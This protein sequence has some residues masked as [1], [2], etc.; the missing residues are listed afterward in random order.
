M[1]LILSLNL[2]QVFC[3]GPVCG[4]DFLFNFS[5]FK[6]LFLF[7]RKGQCVN[8]REYYKKLEWVLIKGKKGIKA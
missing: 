3:V 8:L 4:E 7:I 1:P 6:V 2:F 5:S